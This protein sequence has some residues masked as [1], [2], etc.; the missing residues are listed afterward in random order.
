MQLNPATSAT[1]E[2]SFSTA[3]MK[4]SVRLKINQEWFGNVCVL[5]IHKSRPDNL[6]L[7]DAVNQ[8]TD[9]NKNR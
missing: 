3:I 4:T 6:N 9:L 8:C 7:V 5:N 2:K 1:G